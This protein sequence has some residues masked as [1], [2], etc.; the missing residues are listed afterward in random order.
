VVKRSTALRVRST[1]A[2]SP[3]LPLSPS[4]KRFADE[5]FAGADAGNAVRSYLIVHEGASYATASVNASELLKSTRVREY[6]QQLHNAAIA[7]TAGELKE[8][9]ALLPAAQSLIVSTVEGR[10]KNR[11]A[12][13][14]AIYLV[15]RVCGTPT[16]VASTE[17]VH[18]D[19][20]R[21]A[22]AV[23]AFTRRMSD[24]QRRRVR[25]GP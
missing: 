10:V 13:E 7:M 16:N 5:Y 12:L 6:L 24:E 15:N 14:A 17:V 22:R 23:A 9:A 3:A 19:E 18:R 8:W 20:G 1:E 2:A 11:V 4:E 21:I 25:D